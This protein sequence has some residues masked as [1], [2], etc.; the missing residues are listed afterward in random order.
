[1]WRP[2]LTGIEILGIVVLMAPI[3]LYFLVPP[4]LPQRPRRALQRFFCK[5]GWHRGPFEQVPPPETMSNEL[6]QY[7]YWQPK[8]L[9]SH[10]GFEGIVDS[11]G[12]LF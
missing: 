10:C 9:C 11:Q 1:M 7:Y 8:C 6:R 5:I 12:N 4:I 2:I 3:V